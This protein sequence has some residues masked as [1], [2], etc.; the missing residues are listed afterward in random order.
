M[1]AVG[2]SGSNESVIHIKNF[3]YTALTVAPGAVV[4]AH[5][6]DGVA[7]TVTSDQAGLFNVN[8]PAGAMVTFKAPT[9]PGRYAYHCAY[10]GNMH[11]VLVVS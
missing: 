4:T 6:M 10:H 7:H 8:V 9:K 3:S 11:G 2:G 5:N 1:S